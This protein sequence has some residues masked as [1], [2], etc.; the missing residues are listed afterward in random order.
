MQSLKKFLTSNEYDSINS[1]TPEKK[2]LWKNGKPINYEVNLTPKSQDLP[3]I[4]SLNFA[5]TVIKK[6]L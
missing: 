2:F 4:V 5:I 6:E 1:V 3:N